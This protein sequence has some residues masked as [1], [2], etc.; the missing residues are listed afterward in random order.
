[1]Q[2]ASFTTS[3]FPQGGS[4]LLCFSTCMRF[5]H[6]SHRYQCLWSLCLFI[7]TVPELWCLVNHLR[8]KLHD[9]KKK[10]VLIFNLYSLHTCRMLFVFQFAKTTQWQGVP[11]AERWCG[12]IYTA[13]RLHID[14]VIEEKQWEQQRFWKLMPAVLFV[15]FYFTDS[16]I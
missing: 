11:N 7:N 8:C 13:A 12:R 9:S 4:N 15:Y 3:I 14:K 10:K 16:F 6:P 2:N 5:L 1:M